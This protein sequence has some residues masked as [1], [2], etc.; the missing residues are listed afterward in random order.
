MTPN[1]IS[2]DAAATAAEAAKLMKQHHVGDVLVCREGQLCGIVTDRDIVVRG[3][4][5][6]PEG[7]GATR[8]DQ[9]CTEEI[10]SLTPETQVGEAIRLMEERA[11]RRVPI[12]ED[13]KPVGIVSLGDL[14]MAR[15]RDSA[16]GRISAA[17][18]SPT[19]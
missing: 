16:L 2:L 18:P 5:E 17:P 3:L 12:V 19:Q 13:G 11:I 7:I 10:A 9:L 15:D 4:A 8:L 1:P 14:A 6:D